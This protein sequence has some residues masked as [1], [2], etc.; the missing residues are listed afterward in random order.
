M[1]LGIGIDIIEINRIKEALA[2]PR[3]TN[4][5]FTDG[6]QVYCESRG[7]GR[8]ASY[9]AR[10]AGKEAVLKALGSGLSGGQ[11]RDVEILPDNSGR[12]AVK[13]Y[14]YFADLA[15]RKGMLRLYTFR[16]PMLGYMR[17]HR[18]LSREVV[19]MKVSKAAEMRAID[20]M[21][22]T[23]FGLPGVV[24][25]ENAGAA[26]ARKVQQLLGGSGRQENLHFRRQGQ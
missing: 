26:V 15:R 5:V 25:M 1:I 12:P 17:S 19:R 23:N 20:Q 3:F 24:L 21:T 6:E 11:W 9:A 8:Y 2:R 14:G 7:L 16:C 4:R 10:F 22:I 13:L 18:L